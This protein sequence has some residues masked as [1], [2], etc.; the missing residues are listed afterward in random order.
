[1]KT[2]DY[3]HRYRGYWSDDGK[4]RIYQEVRQETVVV[5]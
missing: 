2:H 4:C 3:I 1:V 5:C